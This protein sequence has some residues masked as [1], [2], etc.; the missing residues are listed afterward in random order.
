MI[1]HFLVVVLFDDVSSTSTM[2]DEITTRMLLEHMQAMKSELLQR[3]SSLEIK[4]T[5]LANTMNVG[6]EDA[7][8]H[9]Q[10]LQEDLEVTIL[11]VG[12][13]DKKLAHL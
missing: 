2:A 7:R 8:L 1:V 9:R 4:V 6:F 12:K 3:I 11:M 10:A 5:T 13:H